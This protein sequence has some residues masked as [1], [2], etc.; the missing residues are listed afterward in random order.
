MQLEGKK[1]HWTIEQNWL[2]SHPVMCSEHISGR[3]GDEC[4]VSDELLLEWIIAAAVKMTDV[5]SAQNLFY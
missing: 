1:S 2:E 3:G 4:A 5:K